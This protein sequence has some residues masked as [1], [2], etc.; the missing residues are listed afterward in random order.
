MQIQTWE[1]NT[2]FLPHN[3][4]NGRHYA[5][6][7]C[8]NKYAKGY[9]QHNTN[10]ATTNVESYDDEC[11]CGSEC[12]LKHKLKQWTIWQQRMLQGK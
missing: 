9:V 7:I 4:I 5:N 10:H 1:C 11:K 12:Q 8:G 3:D 6:A 2:H